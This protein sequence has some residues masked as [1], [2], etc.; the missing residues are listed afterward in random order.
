MTYEDFFSSDE[1]AIYKR[2][3]RGSMRIGHAARKVAKEMVGGDFQ[4]GG[5]ELV[6]TEHGTFALVMAH[7]SMNTTEKW[8]VQSEGAEIIVMGDDEEI[9]N[10]FKLH[11]VRDGVKRFHYRLAQELAK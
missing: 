10:W 3:K 7:N 8:A 6:L 9:A 11:H 1:V 4:L 5:R 2:V